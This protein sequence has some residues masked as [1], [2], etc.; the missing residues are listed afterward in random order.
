MGI[1]ERIYKKK[2][3]RG[4]NFRSIWLR[5]FSDFMCLRTVTAMVIRS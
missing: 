4:E 2:R 5:K 3:L 1:T